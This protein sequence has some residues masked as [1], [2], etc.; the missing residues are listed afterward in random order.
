MSPD[1]QRFMIFLVLCAILTV[2]I[3]ICGG[4]H[5]AHTESTDLKCVPEEQIFDMGEIV[6]PDPEG[7]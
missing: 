2:L 1:N 7:E 5:T 6:R 3:V 4:V